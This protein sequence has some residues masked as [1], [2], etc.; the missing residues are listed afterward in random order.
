EDSSS[1]HRDAPSPGA[2]NRLELKSAKTPCDDVRFREAFIRSV[3]VDGGIEALYFDTAP[4]S[5]SLLYSV[6]PLGYS[7]DS[8]FTQDVEQA[9]EQIGRASCRERENALQRT[10]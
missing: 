1:R 7:D 5:H 8:L 9:N 3:D 4:R 2:A 10:G 6:E